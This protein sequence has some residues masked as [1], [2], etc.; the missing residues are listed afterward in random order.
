MKKS[1]ALAGAMIALANEAEGTHA[2]GHITRIASGVIVKGQILKKG[3]SDTEVAACA[4]LT[5]VGLYVALDGADA[6]EIVPCA[7]LGSYTGTVRVL[8]SGA[9]AVG[10]GI[11]P[12]G[13]AVATGLTIGRALVAASDGNPVEIAHK[14]CA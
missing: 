6:G 10:D 11:S 13:T 1:I 2:N 5:D 7:V 12:L 8:A 9:V 4:E 14:V 3:S